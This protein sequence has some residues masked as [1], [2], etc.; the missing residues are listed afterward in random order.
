MNQI[1]YIGEILSFLCAIFWAIAIILFRKSGDFIKPFSLNLFKNSIALILFIITS[2]IFG[3]TIFIDAPLK[4]YIILALSGIIGIAF[5]DTFFFKV[6]NKLGASLTEIINC[7]YMPIVI[8]LSLIFLN[9]SFSLLQ[10]FGTGLIILS[11]NI[12]SWKSPDHKLSRKEL[13][14]GILMA[15]VSMLL[16]AL[17]IVMLKPILANYPILWSVEV[18]LFFGVVSMAIFTLF[19]KDKKIIVSVFIPSRGWKYM[20][21]AVVIG[22]YFAMITWIAGVKFT[23]ANIASALNQ[24]NVIF[25]FILA[26]IFLHEKF[27][28][29][30][31]AGVILAFSGV[32]LVT[33]G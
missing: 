29:K 23:Q 21:P 11:I 1:P 33:I 5:A 28:Y 10:F 13:I 18:R 4:V 9:E 27:T 7:L 30:K 17:S 32:I 8:V 16:T 22:A 25:V 24:T 3:S 19:R 31:A 15:L 2:V 26:A 6:L 12:S 20:I 14:T